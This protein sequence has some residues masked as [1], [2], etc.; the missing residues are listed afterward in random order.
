MT[1]STAYLFMLV[2]SII[3]GTAPAVIKFSLAS[4]PPLIF[5]VYRFFISSVIALL[6][7]GFTRQKLPRKANQW[8]G[9]FWTSTVGVT[10]ALGLLFFGFDKTTSLAGNVL[11]A[12]GPLVL[13]TAGGVFLHERVTKNEL[14]GVSIALI[15]TLVIVLSPLLNGG[16]GKIVGA[17]EGNLLIVLAIIADAGATILAKITI[18]NKISA[19]MLAHLSFV[20]AF[21]TIAPLAL[22]VHGTSG[23]LRAIA[24]APLSAHLGVWFM[25]IVSGTIAYTLRNRA[26]QTI[27]V[28]ETAPFTY[29]HP[30]LGAPLSVLW[31]GEKITTPFIFGGIII[32]VGVVIAEIKKHRGSNRKRRMVRRQKV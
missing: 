8:S 23:I 2:V 11:T 1:R 14:T 18:R 26:V 32:A 31:L 15:G 13:I 9:I 27:E 10:I 20:I 22:T 3:W 19:S 21:T 12:L 24:S 28:S 25:A 4:F 17:L 5:L 6:W 16:Y 29:L 30:L 7:F